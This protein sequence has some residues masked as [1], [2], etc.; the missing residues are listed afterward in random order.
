MRLALDEVEIA[1]K[2]G[3]GPTETSRKFNECWSDMRTLCQK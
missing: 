1:A 2:S 3:V